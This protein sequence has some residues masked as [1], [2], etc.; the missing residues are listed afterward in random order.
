[1]MTPSPSGGVA[2]NLFWRHEQRIL[3]RVC[4]H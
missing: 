3:P 1:M 2:V 4:V